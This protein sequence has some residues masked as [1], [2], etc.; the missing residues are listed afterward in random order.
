[1]GGGWGGFC[2]LLSFVHSR[3]SPS[4]PPPPP[5]P[6]DLARLYQSQH[7]Y[8]EAQKTYNQALL[9]LRGSLPKTHPSIG[10]CL[11][12]MGEVEVALGHHDKAESM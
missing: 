2:V 9:M 5:P 1:V 10:V 4:P 8:V 7:Q 3:Y 12:H 6:P 11:G